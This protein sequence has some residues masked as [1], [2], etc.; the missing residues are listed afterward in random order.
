MHQEL[1][2]LNKKKKWIK[3]VNKYFTKYKN[4]YK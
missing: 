2:E 3:N 1:L 4:I